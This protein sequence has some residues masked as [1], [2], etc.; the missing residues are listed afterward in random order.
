MIKK[1]NWGLVGY[2][3]FGK[4]IEKSFSYCKFSNLNFIASKT[5]DPGKVDNLNQTE[6]FFF[7]SYYDLIENKEIKNIYIATTN[8]LHK[9]LI[10]LA[11]N[12]KKNIICEKPAC[13][14]LN[15]IIECKNAIEK[16]SIFFIEGLMYLHHPQI[17]KA[18]EIIR[19][20][21]IGKIKKIVSN[22]GYK[23]GRKFLIF[24]LKKIDT[25]SRLFNP[26]LGGGSIYD[27]GCYPLTAALTFFKLTDLENEVINHKFFRE[28][29]AYGVD[30]SAKAILNFKCGGIAELCV[31]IRKN[32]EN[33]IEIIGTKGS[34]KIINPWIP[35][36]D[37]T[38]ELSIN[39]SKK[40]INCFF[41]KDIYALEIDNA[42]EAINKNLKELDYPKINIDRTLEYIKIMEKWRFSD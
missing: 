14:S 22:F 24:E 21:E 38:L 39:K 10:I 6:K 32:L 20:N 29:G 8:N 3:K 23:V 26:K 7:K 1:L 40:I 16:N 34:I 11:A 41:D 42:S 31:S 25:K 4:K 30:E 19:N 27:L 37:S 9:E 12:N 35:P 13:L 33:V 17:N 28:D 18:I 36:P 15:E 2:G 5:F